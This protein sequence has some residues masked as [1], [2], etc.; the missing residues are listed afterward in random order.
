MIKKSHETQQAQI[1][2]FLG[3]TAASNSD[4]FDEVY[5]IIKDLA[6]FNY[7]KFDPI[8]FSCFLSCQ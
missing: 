7:K 4:M 8:Y 5:Q 1:E 3:E 2:Y 6:F